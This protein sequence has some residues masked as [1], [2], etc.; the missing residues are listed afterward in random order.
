MKRSMILSTAANFM[1]PLLLLF[2]FF[3]LLR[4]HNFPGGGFVGGL[5]A[6]IAYALYIVAKGISETKKLLNIE[7]IFVI[8]IGLALA[9]FSGI[10][11][12]LYDKYFMEGVWMNGS[13]PVI[14]KIGTPLL[15]D[16]GVYF[17]V[18]GISTKIIFALAEEDDQ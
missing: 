2:S 4:G 5:T 15:F 3:L 6:A 7:P 10:I 18:L 14:G 1:I 11:S 8:S 17:V 16:L 9:L 12:L 13:L